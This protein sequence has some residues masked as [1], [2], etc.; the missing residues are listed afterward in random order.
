MSYDRQSALI[1]ARAA[2]QAS[3]H[4]TGCPAIV[5]LA[6]WALESGWGKESPGNNCF[7]IK[8]YTGCAGAQLLWTHEEVNGKLEPVE[9]LFATFETL[10]D[11]FSKHARL[12]TQGFRYFPAYYRYRQNQD[13]TA[14]VRAIAPIYSTS[15]TYASEILQLIAELRTL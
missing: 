5:T 4:A 1:A 6:Q 7:G 10:A 3:E 15:S 14:F 2:A 12:L 13:V 11:C 8:V 9:G